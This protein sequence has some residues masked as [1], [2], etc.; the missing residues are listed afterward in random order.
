MPMG[1]IASTPV[2]VNQPVAVNHIAP[3]VAVN[4]VAQGALTGTKKPGIAVGA[5]VGEGVVGTGCTGG[6]VVGAVTKL[7]QMGATTAISVGT[8]AGVGATGGLCTLGAAVATGVYCDSTLARV[9][10]HPS[11]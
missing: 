9:S 6:A 4:N 5:V 11:N 10:R 7:G 1:T 2:V 3:A 8:S